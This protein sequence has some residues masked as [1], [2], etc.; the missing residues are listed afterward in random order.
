MNTS[1]RAHPFAGEGQKE[2]FCLRESLVDPP[3]KTE[4]DVTGLYFMVLRS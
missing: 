3:L 4:L 1:V 2:V